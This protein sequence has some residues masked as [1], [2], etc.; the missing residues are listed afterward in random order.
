MGKRGIKLI[1]LVLIVLLLVGACLLLSSLN[2]EP[3]GV[4]EEDD[5]I[6]LAEFTSDGVSA[7]NYTYNGTTLSFTQTAGQ[8]SYDADSEFP[9]A[10]NTITT[11]IESITSVNAERKLDNTDD[12]ANYGFDS[13]ALA[14]TVTYMG[15]DKTFEVGDVNNYTGGYY[16]RYNNEIYMTDETLLTVFGKDLYDYLTTTELPV[17]EN[18]VGFV[19]DGIEMTD[20]AMVADLAE[21]YSSM[22]RG[23][24]ADYRSKESY[25]FDGSEHMVVVNYTVDTP[26]TDASGNPT[27]TITTNKSYN[28]SY[29]YVGENAYIMLQDDDLIYNVSGTE[30]FD[31]FVSSD[32]ETIVKSTVE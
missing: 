29:S 32:T 17:L 11:M 21:I 5:T 4:V 26:V 15:E 12:P 19:V 13:P 28:F 18:T 30:S 25:G 3:E 23:D 31:A 24:V 9:L 10:Q 2:K 22:I 16:L 7:F 1:I 14:L 20:E 27:S 6:L 8:W